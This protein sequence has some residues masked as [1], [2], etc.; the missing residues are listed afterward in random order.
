MKKIALFDICDTI[1][2]FNSTYKFI[3]YL[4]PNKKLPQK[5]ILFKIL[6]KVVY[7]T[8]KLDLIRLYNI[9]LLRYFSRND[10]NINAKTF[11][12]ESK[13]NNIIID[14]IND[15]KKENYE[16]IL[17]SATIDPIASQLTQYLKLDGYH[18]TS[19]N[20]NNDNVCL[21]LIGT[22]LLSQKSDIIKN[23][24]NN[25]YHI[26]FFTDNKSDENCI[27]ECNKFVAV[28]P[29]NRK[30]NIKYWNK[31]NISEILEL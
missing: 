15:M 23:Y 1:L 28:I 13:F 31:K 2:P 27:K 3:E 7:K 29:R 5:Y 6:N 8:I 19:L 26:T 24:K 16:V 4:Y 9:R 25:G 30:N 10:L 12:Q 22:D 17:L 14:K 18:S 11:I 20:F 21:G